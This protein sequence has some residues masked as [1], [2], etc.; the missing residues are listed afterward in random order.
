MRN[1]RNSE[2]SAASCPLSFARFCSSPALLQHF[3]LFK[4]LKINYSYKDRIMKSSLAGGA[5]ELSAA[6]LL[7][8]IGPALDQVPDDVLLQ[9]RHVGASGCLELCL[10]LIPLMSDLHAS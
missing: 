2:A 6:P 9:V 5:M 4:T 8:D 10:H 1:A 3:K 7:V